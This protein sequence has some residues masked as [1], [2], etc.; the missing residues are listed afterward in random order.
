M[1][2]RFSPIIAACVRSLAPNFERMHLTRLFTVSSVM[3]S[4]SAI[5][6]FAWPV[7]ISRGTLISAG[8]NVSSVACVAISYETSGEKA[9]FPVC[10]P[11]IVSNS[12]LCNAFFSRYA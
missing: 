1:I 10:T 12:S 2:P 5:C 3:E 11:R 7:A 6:L 4:W 8:V 9:F